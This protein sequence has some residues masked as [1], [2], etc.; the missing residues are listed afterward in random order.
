MYKSVAFLKF[1]IV[2]RH[3]LLCIYGRDLHIPFE[4]PFQYEN[5]HFPHIFIYLLSCGATE[6]SSVKKMQPSS[7]VLWKLWQGPGKF[8]V[9]ICFRSSSYL[10][11]RLAYWL[12]VALRYKKLI[13]KFRNVRINQ[14]YSCIFY[15]YIGILFFKISVFTFFFNE[16]ELKVLFYLLSSSFK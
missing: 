14:S 4:W 9:L 5:T 7:C 13:L 8:A 10:F 11:F 3:E 2:P 1:K 6:F 16:L 12:I 15:Q